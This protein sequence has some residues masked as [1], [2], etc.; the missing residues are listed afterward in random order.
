MRTVKSAVN[1]SLFCG[2]RRILKIE[3]E[4]NGLKRDVTTFFIADEFDYNTINIWKAVS[5]VSLQS[6][7][8]KSKFTSNVIIMPVSTGELSVLIGKADKYDEI[9]DTVRTLFENS[10]IDFDINWRKRFI[11]QIV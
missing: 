4:S 1:G 6:S 2:I 10:K 8:D 5:S 11:S 7:N 3:E 9:I